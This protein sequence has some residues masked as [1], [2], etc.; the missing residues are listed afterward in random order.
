MKAA[1]GHH[2]VAR[3][4][5]LRSPV[6]VLSAAFP[7]IIGPLIQ[8]KDKGQVSLLAKEMDRLQ[9]QEDFETHDAL[10]GRVLAREKEGSL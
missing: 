10:Q 1:S 6:R 4:Y 5:R 9:E 8:A 7:D 3:P 2:R